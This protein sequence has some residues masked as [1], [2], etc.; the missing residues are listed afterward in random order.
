MLQKRV[1]SGE[2]VVCI[3]DKGK[4]LTA[5]SIESYKRQGMVHVGSDHE[6]GWA[7]IR[8]AQ[9]RLTANARSLAKI[10]RLGEALGDRNA[11]RAWENISGQACSVPVL[12]VVPKL[13]KPTNPNG[14][15][16][17]RPIVGAT[18]GLTARAGDLLAEVIGNISKVT[19]PETES[20]STEEVLHV[21]I[22]TNNKCKHLI[23]FREVRCK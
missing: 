20:T 4:Q 15:P 7:E 23:C 17:T 1:K 14:D 12:R 19:N 16:K 13:H 5:C 8:A 11:K 6:V 22:H 3:A 2:I 21:K 9:V 10:F 18:S